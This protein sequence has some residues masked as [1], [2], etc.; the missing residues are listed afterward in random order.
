MAAEFY[1]CQPAPVSITL[2][3]LSPPVPE[4]V[5]QQLTK[6]SQKKVQRGVVFLVAFGHGPSN[7][8]RSVERQR[9]QKYM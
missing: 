9:V 4:S 2:V 5:I 8:S 3:T 1:A 7:S 6:L